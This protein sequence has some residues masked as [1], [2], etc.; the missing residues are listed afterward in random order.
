MVLNKSYN[1]I[2]PKCVIWYLL[3]LL[4]CY[5][6]RLMIMALLALCKLNLQTCMRSN[7]LGLDVWFLVRPFFYFQTLCVRTVTALAH[8]CGL[9]W[10][11]A[12][13][14]CD[15]YHNLMSWLNDCLWSIVEQP[16]RQWLGSQSMLCYGL[17]QVVHSSL[18]N[19]KWA[20]SWQNQQNGMCNQ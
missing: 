11:F 19:Q 6:S 18:C 5:M 15:K 17:E 10:A 7:R 20:T 9:A 16:C 14:L 2:W 1:L 13:R 8:L 3:F 4:I 12:V